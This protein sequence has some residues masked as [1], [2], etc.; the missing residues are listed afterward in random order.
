MKKPTSTTEA[1]ARGGF[2]LIEINLVL[3]I[4]GIGL[5]ALLGLFPVGLRQ[6]GLA[7]GDTVQAVFADQVLNTLQAQAST[8]TNWTEWT[9]FQASVL[10]DAKIS[11]KRDPASG[12]H[13]LKANQD[14]KIDDYLVDGNTIR[15]RLSFQPVALPEPLNSRGF[16][17]R[18]MRAFIQV[19]ERAE[20]DLLNAT[21]YC[22]DFVFMGP[23]PR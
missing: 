5:V 23:P 20:S 21:V 17:G 10:Q 4:V 22:T 15:Y 2:T 18:L 6:A 11:T 16:G 9:T 1:A 8:I 12:T 14:V 7:T 19:S 13:T 3:L